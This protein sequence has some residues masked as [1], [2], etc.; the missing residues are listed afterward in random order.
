MVTYSYDRRPEAGYHGKYKQK[1]KPRGWTRNKLL[2]QGIPQHNADLYAEA[3]DE[4]LQKE[5][6]SLHKID[7]FAWVENFRR[8]G[9]SPQEAARELLDDYKKKHG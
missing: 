9:K 3:V 2:Q 1:L 4:I 8:R 5:G 6:Y 7:P